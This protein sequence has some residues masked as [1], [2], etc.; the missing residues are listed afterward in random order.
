[1]KYI[2]GEQKRIK[3]GCIN[4]FLEAGEKNSKE[5]QYSHKIKGR[6]KKKKKL[7]LGKSAVLNTYFS[8]SWYRIRRQHKAEININEALGISS[9]SINKGQVKEYLNDLNIY[10]SNGPAHILWKD[11]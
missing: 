5:I 10:D 8:Y 3:E 1:M 9:S 2:L 11:F 4:T 6:V 7:A